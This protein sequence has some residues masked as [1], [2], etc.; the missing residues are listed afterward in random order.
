MTKIGIDLVMASNIEEADRKF[1]ENPY[2]D[3]II[4]DC[5]VPGDVVNTAGLV[6]EIRKTFSG[7]ILANSSQ[8]C[9]TKELMQA[10]ASHQCDKLEV[11]REA[12]KILGL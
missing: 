11:H 3:L 5:C 1:H 9:N 8:L 10:G 12:V 6:F 4:M 7:P 2:F